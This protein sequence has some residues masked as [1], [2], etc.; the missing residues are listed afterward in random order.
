MSQIVRPLLFS[1]AAASLAF[2]GSCR[3]V[4]E[5]ASSPEQLAQ[6]PSGLSIPVPLS[7]HEKPAAHKVVLC[8]SNAGEPYQRVQVN[9][10]MDLMRVAADVELAA[11]DARGS[12]K[13]QAEQLQNIAKT[14]P[15]A[16]IVEPVDVEALK[17]GVGELREAGITVIGLDPALKDVCTS[18]VFCDQKKIGT[19]AGQLIVS[20]LQRKAQDAGSAEVTGRVVQIQGD[21]KSPA[22]KARGEGFIEALKAQLGIVLVHDTPSKGDRTDAVL[23]FGEA[24]RLQKSIDAVYAHNDMIAL[25]VSE[26]GA[27]ENVRDQLLIVG[28]DGASGPGGGLEMLGKSQID[29]TIHQPLLVDFAWR[30]IEKMIKDSSFKPKPGYEIEPV[31]F[32]PKNFDELKAKGLPVPAF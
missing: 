29:A 4:E 1:L 5:T 2:L 14:K 17:E 32:T 15:T 10:L 28:T 25:G 23:R 16:V 11:T 12:V 26:V 31:L 30:V 24:L 22:S 18:V 27:K 13:R 6:D 21:E 7:R 9:L 3:P 8:L 20:A 19:M